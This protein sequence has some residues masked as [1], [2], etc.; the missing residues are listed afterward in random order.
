MK[1]TLARFAISTWA[2]Y[3]R[4]YF[5][6]M[7]SIAFLFTGASFAWIYYHLFPEI[8]EQ[9]GVPLHYNV[10]S[11]VDS[12]G[13][14][15]WIFL[16][17]AVALALFIINNIIAALVAKRDYVLSYMAIAVATISSILVFVAVLHIVQLNLNY[18]G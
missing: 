6:M 18:Y 16:A 11:G 15:E 9:P 7:N 3:K 14:W 12:F 4:P 2:L 17:P 8:L 10:H 5:W 13:S 1:K